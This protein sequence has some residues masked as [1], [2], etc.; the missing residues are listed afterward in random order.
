M[1]ISRR[2][3]LKGIGTAAVVGVSQTLFPA[4]MPKLVFSPKAHAQPNRDVLVAIFQRGG[5]DGLSVVVPYGEGANYY[6]RRPTI[7]IPEPTGSDRA[8]ID[9]NGFF[10][11]HP[12]LLPLKEV[13][14]AGALTIVHAAGSPDPT[15]SHFD[16]MEYM[17]KGIPGDKATSTGWI[18]RYLQ[19]TAQQNDSPFRAVGMGTMM[20]ASLRGPVSALT[21]KSISDFH[22]GGR[23]DQLANIQSI[24]AR[25]Y[26]IDAP[27]NL[28]ETQA[29]SVYQTMDVL[30]A[31]NAV[32]YTPAN[33]AVYPESD[34]GMALRQVAQLIKAGVG[35]EVACIDIG[36]WDTHEYQGSVDGEIADL[37]RDLGA[38]LAAFHTDLGD[39]MSNVTVVSMSEFG[40]RVS[41]NA[42]Q[43]TDHGHGNVMFVMGGASTGQIYSDW[44]TLAPEALVDGDLQITTDY[45]DV[46]SEIITKRL[47]SSALDHIFPGYTPYQ[48]NIIAE[49]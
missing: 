31:L 7:A 48:R 46:L 14:D 8:A 33:G 9:L 16:A 45:R 39:T 40:R 36:G 23:D 43:G 49:R 18:N 47:G 28:L 29:G 22:L 35:L 10:G 26:R 15:R 12:S 13:Y 24:I 27:T 21:L 4:W 20:P 34:F 37:L 6:D 41:E 38:G 25:M 30:K 1:S 2:S 32:G 17:E 44:P 19:A 42:S 11:L 3:L 5:M